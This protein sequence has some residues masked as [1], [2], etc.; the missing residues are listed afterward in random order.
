[1][2][3]FLPH[4]GQAYAMGRNADHGT[5]EQNSVSGLSPYLRRRMITEAEVVN[6]VLK[7]HTADAAE[8]FLQEVAWRSYWKGWLEMRPGIWKDY[9]ATLLR[10][11]SV[12][13]ADAALHARLA[14][15]YAGETGLECM[16][17]WV[18]ELQNTGYLHNHAR[19]WFAGIWIYTLGLP[20]EWGA[21]FFVRH[22]LDADPASNTLS[23]RWVAGLH[24]PG[25]RYKPTASN[26]R[27]NS[28]SRFSSLEE[29]A[30]NT[31]G[32]DFEPLPP[33]Q[34]LCLPVVDLPSRFTLVLCAEDWATDL[35]PLLVERAD[36]I[37]LLDMDTLSETW[38]PSD[39]VVAF[40]QAVLADVA[41]RW[42]TVCDVEVL[43]LSRF[44]EALGK[45][46]PG[47]VVMPFVPQGPIRDVLDEQWQAGDGQPHFW[48]RDLDRQSWPHATAGFFR[49]WKK[50]RRFWTRPSP[51]GD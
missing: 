44:A 5:M 29:I 4:A 32:P 11:A 38:Q 43:S 45:N 13:K 6:A 49:F 24:T 9:R 46:F 16:D 37:V 36:R 7:V 48:I 33:P 47:P 26:I 27:K 3:A 20:W 10:K 17:V 35:P 41:A 31:S 19:M 12:L 22:L 28:G 25:K 18:R 2:E 40:D 15:V 50:G 23:W 42:S 39:R 51:T 14:S 21:D 30:W 34:D 1:L 8:K